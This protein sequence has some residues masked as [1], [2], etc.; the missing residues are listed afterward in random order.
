[1]NAT[2]RLNA[3][4]FLFSAIPFRL[5]IDCLLQQDQSASE[6]ASTHM[7]CSQ[8]GGTEGDGGVPTVRC[9]PLTPFHGPAVVVQPADQ[10]PADTP[11]DQAASITESGHGPGHGPALVRVGSSDNNAQAHSAQRQGT[12][13]FFRAFHPAS[14]AF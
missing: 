13:P 10:Q 5:Q 6:S 12:T 9:S 1:M 14:S 7:D 4:V 3:I 8:S 2:G 11:D